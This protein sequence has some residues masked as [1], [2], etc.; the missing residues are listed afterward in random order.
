VKTDTT[1]TQYSVTN[2]QDYISDTLKFRTQR[3]D[4][5]ETYK[6]L[7]GLYDNMV[8]PNVPI[9]SESRTRGN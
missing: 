3:G 4:M 6:I 1:S 8:T 5:I 9:L 7:A 2:L